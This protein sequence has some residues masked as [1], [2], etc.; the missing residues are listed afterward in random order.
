MTTDSN[1]KLVS[2]NALIWA[3]ATMASVILP[4]VTDSLTD[5]RS[6]F[7]RIF[8]Q[9]APLIAGMFISSISVAKAVRRPVS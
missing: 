9:A 3:V 4:F 8:V 5:G 1:K 7:A 2:I 6:A